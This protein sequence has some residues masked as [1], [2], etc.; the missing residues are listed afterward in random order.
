[1]KA[2]LDRRSFLATAAALPFVGLGGLAR[3]AASPSTRRLLILVEL[4]GGNDALNTVVPYDDPGYARLR[5]RIALDRDQVVKLTPSVGLHP[6]LARLAPIWEAKRL[7]IVRGVGY[8]EPNLSHF[9]SIEIWDTASRSDEYLEDGWLTR[10][11]VR[12]PSPSAFAADGVVVGIGG[13]G[14]LSGHGAR[15]IS[16]ANPE[17]FLRNARLAHGEGEARNAALAHI[18]R[19]E[20]DVVASAQRLHAQK[21][22]TTAFPQGAFGSA[23]ATAAQLAA[24]ASGI[25]VVRLTLNGFDTH[26]NQQGVHQNLLRQLGDGMLA[27]RDA[28]VEID[29]WD[30]TVVATYSEFGRRPRQNE[31]GGTDH[32]TASAH[33]VMGGR[34]RGGLYG[35]QPALDRLDSTGNAPFVLDFRRYYATFL[36]RHWDIPSAPVLGGRFEPLDFI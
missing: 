30:T 11:F 7:A 29:R 35:E 22:F 17:Q 3:A 19:V 25:A 34:V 32:G 10:A 28:L 5:P 15:A 12:S 31:S 20:R 8:P 14:P 4:K 2:P 1:M 33:L 18:L 27:L 9:R 13:M 36:E 24:N 21:S 16:L 26:A 23:T 6:A